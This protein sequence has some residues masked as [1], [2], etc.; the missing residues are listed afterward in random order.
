MWLLWLK[1]CSFP[2]LPRSLEV[3]DVMESLEYTLRDLGSFF[4]ITFSLLSF[5]AVLWPQSHKMAAAPPSIVIMFQAKRSSSLLFLIRKT[6]FSRSL[7]K[8][9]FIF[10]SLARMLNR[11][12]LLDRVLARGASWS[13]QLWGTGQGS[14]AVTQNP[15]CQ[16]IT[17]PFTSRDRTFPFQNQVTSTVKAHIYEGLTTCQALFSSSDRNPRFI[18]TTTPWSQ[19]GY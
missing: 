13:W 15:L 17:L 10:T 8:K 12:Q 6:R 3:G 11:G 9:V 14:P 16:T 5:V 2:H 19:Y 4:F 18:V 1:N 7:S